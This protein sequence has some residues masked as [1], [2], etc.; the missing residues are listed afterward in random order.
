MKLLNVGTIL[1]QKGLNGCCKVYSTT[2]F[3]DVR[4]KQGNKVILHNEQTSVTKEVTVKDYYS[5]GQFD[6]VTFEEF[7]T[8]EAITP[9][10]NWKIC[11]D[12]ET[13][14]LEDGLYYFS[15]LEGC[16]VIDK[17]L[18]EIGVVLEIEEYTGRRSFRIRLNKNKKDILVPYIDNFIKEIDI[19]NKTVNVE[20]IDGMVE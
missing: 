20:L 8:F 13:S 10:L 3:A 15:D 1:K 7:P 16:K 12:K 18:G 14:P 2:D 17:R 9:Y 4:Y 11:I 6:Y 5:Q 19:D